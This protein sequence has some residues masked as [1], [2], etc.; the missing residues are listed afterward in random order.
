[1]CDLSNNTARVRRLYK[2]EAQRR[3]GVLDIAHVHSHTGCYAND[4]A[5]TL[6]NIGKGTGPY[7]RQLPV[8]M[9]LFG[10]KI[11]QDEDEYDRDAR[12]QLAEGYPHPA[13]PGR[14]CCVR[15][16]DEQVQAPD[17]PS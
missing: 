3:K 1:M 5:D 7:S 15:A 9:H 11:L 13:V 12:I 8:K 14:Y 10:D 4:R 2:H 16:M 6:A 17:L